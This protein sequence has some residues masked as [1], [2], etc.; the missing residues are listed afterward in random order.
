L[1]A[2]VVPSLGNLWIL[3]SAHD[4]TLAIHMSAGADARL[5]SSF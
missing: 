2:G 5:V 4:R 1:W 3:G